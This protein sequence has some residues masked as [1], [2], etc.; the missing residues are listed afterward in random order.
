[1]KSYTPKGRKSF[2]FLL[3]H[4]LREANIVASPPPLVFWSVSFWRCFVRFLRIR[5]LLKEFS[6]EACWSVTC[7]KFT[8]L[9]S[10]S[11]LLAACLPL[12]DC[13]AQQTKHFGTDMDVRFP[14][15]DGILM[16]TSRLRF[17]LL[18]LFVWIRVVFR[19]HIEA[20]VHFLCK[21]SSSVG[22]FMFTVVFILKSDTTYQFIVYGSLVHLK[23]DACSSVCDVVW[24]THDEPQS[25]FK[26]DTAMR[27]QFSEK[28]SEKKS[29]LKFSDASK[30][31]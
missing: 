17:T 31:S 7:V 5:V 6:D 2:F 21:S 22:F 8:L 28:V 18:P 23:Q 24:S 20:L 10:W 12:V 13:A 26:S 4:Q 1:M 25:S 14:C 27:Y 11:V 15:S 16:E 30:S 19:A 3:A 29:H 9:L